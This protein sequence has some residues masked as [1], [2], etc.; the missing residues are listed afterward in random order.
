[1]KFL[2]MCLLLAIIILVNLTVA[3]RALSNSAKMLRDKLRA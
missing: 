3:Q 2:T 1:L